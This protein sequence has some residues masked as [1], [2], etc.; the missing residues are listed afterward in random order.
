MNKAIDVSEYIAKKLSAIAQDYA[1]TAEQ[2]DRAQVKFANNK[3]SITQRW[4]TSSISVF[5]CINRRTV[6]TESQPDRLSADR[7]VAR[8]LQFSK[9]VSG[10]SE[11]RGIARGPFKYRHVRNYDA[12][13]ESMDLADCVRESINIGLAN[14]AKRTAGLAEKSSVSLHTLTSGGVAASDR[15]SRAYFSMRSF[16]ENEGS[17]HSVSVSAGMEGFNFREAAEESALI[18][19][20]S[21]MPKSMPPGTYDV[22]LGHLPAANLFE[23][24]AN[25]ASPFYVESGLS[26]F[27]GKI[28]KRVAD[29]SF[30]MADDPVSDFGA[31]SRK[32]DE[33]GFPAQRT[34]IIRN[35]ILRSYLHSASTAARY[36]AKSTGNAGIIAPR[37][38]S[39]VIEKGNL[40]KDELVEKVKRGILVTNT[41]YTR[42]QNYTTGEFSTIPRDGTFLIEKGRVARPV[43]GVRISD[44]MLDML[45]KS[46]DLGNSSRQVMSWEMETPLTTPVILVGNV[47]ITR[48]AE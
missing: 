42:F 14:G 38:F 40:N 23:A 44:N 43:K 46:R 18:A 29:T 32:F 9:A 36:G 45:M 11:F 24:V 35:G 20:Q 22:I 13:V 25:S 4:M 31:G 30:S 47:R 21:K 6:F 48:S 10:N 34:E 7:A 39:P 17:G 5:A 28:G 15:M 37:A 3:V 16:S 12:A 19:T 27:G 26:F 33:E 41:W 1:I 2:K 8:L